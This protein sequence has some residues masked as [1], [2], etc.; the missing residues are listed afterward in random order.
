MPISERRRRG[1]T[2]LPYFSKYVR[3]ILQMCYKRYFFCRR[4]QRAYDRSKTVTPVGRDRRRVRYWH[5]LRDLP[6][7]QCIIIIATVI[8]IIASA[9]V[10]RARENA[11]EIA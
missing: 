9:M 1:R 7:L 6:L 4:Y 8:I 11:S 2:G 5:T 10:A 3:G